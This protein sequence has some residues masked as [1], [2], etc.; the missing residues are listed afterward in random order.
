MFVCP[1][2]SA[3]HWVSLACVLEEEW[4]SIVFQ[5]FLSGHIKPIL[6]MFSLTGVSSGKFELLFNAEWRDLVYS[7]G[8]GAKGFVLRTPVEVLMIFGDSGCFLS[9]GLAC[10]AKNGSTIALGTGSHPLNLFLRKGQWKLVW[11]CQ[12]LVA[13]TA[14]LVWYLTRPHASKRRLLHYAS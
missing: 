6:P 12:V 10:A 1:I 4:R 8:P 14:W 9:I 7:A 13:A 3:L 11:R 5:S 2:W